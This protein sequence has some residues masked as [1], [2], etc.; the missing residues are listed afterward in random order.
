MGWMRPCL[1]SESPNEKSLAHPELGERKAPCKCGAVF[2]S[3]TRPRFAPLRVWSNPV[4][5]LLFFCF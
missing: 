3:L 4:K 5:F 2:T 1:A